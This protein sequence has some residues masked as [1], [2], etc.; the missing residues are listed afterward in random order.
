MPKHVSERSVT[1]TPQG[2][3]KQG[4]P[5]GV[6][7]YLNEPTVEQ[8]RAGIAAQTCPWC[9]TSKSQS[10]ARIRQLASHTLKAHGINAAAL[11]TAAGLPLS[12][13]GLCAPE[14]TERFLARMQALGRIH[15]DGLCPRCRTNPARRPPQ[16]I[17]CAPCWRDY[18]REWAK[19]NRRRHARRAATR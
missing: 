7:V 12:A 3:T 1:V 9:G 2:E 13:N 6:S 16:I 10:G 19:C 4:F 15:G 11:R 17:Y 5:K 18:Q 8:V 14:R